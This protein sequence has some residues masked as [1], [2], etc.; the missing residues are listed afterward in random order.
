MVAA[1]IDGRSVIRHAAPIR[2]AHPRFIENLGE[3]GARIEW[4]ESA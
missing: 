1:S 4:R 2:R 3:L